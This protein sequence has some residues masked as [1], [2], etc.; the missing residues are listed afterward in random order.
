MRGDPCP[1]RRTAARLRAWSGPPECEQRQ[2]WAKRKGVPTASVDVLDRH[3]GAPA[4]SP[5][6]DSSNK[7]ACARQPH[8]R[9]RLLPRILLRPAR[10]RIPRPAILSL[11]S[12]P[13]RHRA[14]LRFVRQP[15]PSS[16][17][18]LQTPLRLS[19]FIGVHRSRLARPCFDTAWPHHQRPPLRL[20]FCFDYS[21]TTAPHGI[22]KDGGLRCDAA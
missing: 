10:R 16:S 22:L 1:P 12:A 15:W 2:K 14:P 18:K 17:A 13:A 21:P 20:R 19:C 7:S 8:R 6:C 4:A 9:L 11:P 5:Q 3:G